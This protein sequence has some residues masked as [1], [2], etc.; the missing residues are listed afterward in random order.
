MTRGPFNLLVH[1]LVNEH[2]VD[3]G[4]VN[5]DQGDNW[6]MIGRFDLVTAIV[7]TSARINQITLAFTL[8]QYTIAVSWN[9]RLFGRVVNIRTKVILVRRRKC[10]WRL[11]PPAEHAILG[12]LIEQLIALE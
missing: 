12:L 5:V 8:P 4:N 6:S 2:L 9:A 11:I 3:F 7:D 1:H 10:N